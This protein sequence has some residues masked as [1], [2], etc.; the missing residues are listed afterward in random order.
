MKPT[1]LVID[2]DESLL[3]TYKSILKP[4]FEPLLLR[5]SSGLAAALAGQPVDL[6]LLDLM[7]PGRDGLALLPEIK[8]FDRQLP[9][10]MVTALHDIKLAVKA[11]KLGADDYLTKPFEA[12]A[13]LTTLD[14]VLQRR[15]LVRENIYLKQVL[16]EKGYQWDLIGRSAPALKVFALI[17]KAARVPSTVLIT[18]ESGT[19]KELVAHAIHKSSPRADKPFVVVNCAALPE[20][21]IEAELFGHEKGAFTGALERREGKFELADG[22]TLFLDEIGCLPLNLQTRLLRV[23]QDSSIERIGSR[24]PVRVDVRVI[25]ATNLPLEAAAR[26]GEFREDLFYRLNVVRFELAPLRERQADIPLYAEYFINKYAREFNKK[27]KGLTPEALALLTGYAWPGNVRELQNLMERIVVLTDQQEY[28]QAEDIP[29]EAASRN[30]VQEGLKEALVD[31]ERRYIK[32]ALAAA[33]GNQ[34]RAAELLN[35]HR[36]TLVSKMEQLGLK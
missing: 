28:V 33:G 10:I 25:A 29:L 2:D 3:T 22:G 1:V 32:N 21:L 36:T 18:G 4:D 11:I 13:L 12:E 5:D 9:V 16:A 19:G 8:A 31:F 26:R 14:Q 6:V 23:L 7:M 17:E 30:L 27:L 35:I 15:L 20:S 34:T 24:Q